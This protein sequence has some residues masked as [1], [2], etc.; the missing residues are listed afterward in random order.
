[1][2]KFNLNDD[3]V[4]VIIGSG[5]GGNACNELAQKGVKAVILEAGRAPN[6]RISSTTNGKVS[7]SSP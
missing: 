3:S 4:V 2:A 6:S 1:M 7:R 5:A